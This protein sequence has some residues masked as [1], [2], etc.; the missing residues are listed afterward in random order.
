[1]MERTAGELFLEGAPASGF[2]PCEWRRRVCLVPQKP[3]LLPGS[4]RDNL[5]LPWKLKVREGGGPPADG[6]L[7]ELMR[8]AELDG[9]GLDRDVA[10]LSGGQQARVALLRAF[11]AGPEVLLLDEVD[12]ALDDAS[13]CAVGRLTR[14]LVGP[15]MACL[16]IR[17]RASDGFAARVFELR[18]GALSSAAGPAASGDVPCAAGFDPRDYAAVQGLAHPSFAPAG[19]DAAGPA[20]AGAPPA[21]PDAADGGRRA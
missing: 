20:G 18:G 14:A 21:A 10:R 12:A 4:V 3:S 2:K 5:L 6:V 1:M 7:R 16:R 13:A 17:H 11:A 9:V 19:P 15:R 8:L